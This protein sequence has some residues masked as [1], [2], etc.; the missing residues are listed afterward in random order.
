MSI[1]NEIDRIAGNV[2]AALAA[3]ADKGADVPSD[4]T[5][6][7]LAAIIAAIEAG[8]GGLTVKKSR[9]S[10]STT[11][12]TMGHGLGKVPVVAV[13][14]KEASSNAKK[15][16][17]AGL[18]IYNAA[19]NETQTFAVYSSSSSATQFVNT[20]WTGGLDVTPE[21]DSYYRPAMVAH[22]A[23]SS[24]ITFYSP[25]DTVTQFK[26]GYIYSLVVAG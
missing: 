22:S 5:S 13:A 3:C 15:D 19:T 21:L 4:S 17:V 14:I 1:Q 8:G 25:D 26:S 18:A 11:S 23:T 12:H 9:V 10:I 7:D 6:D 24:E 16:R 20:S 2:T